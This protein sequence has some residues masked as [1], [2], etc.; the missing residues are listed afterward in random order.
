MTQPKK[1]LFV[2]IRY[3]HIDEFDAVKE[4]EKVL[5]RRKTAWFGKYGQPLSRDLE[6]IVASGK[7]DVTAILIR[8]G[9]GRGKESSG[10]QFQ[11]F[12]VRKIAISVPENHA[13]FPP[14]Y[15]KLLPRIRSWIQVE[16]HSGPKVDLADLITKSS[17]MP[18]VSS[19]SSSMRGHF[20]CRSRKRD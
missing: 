16:A 10:Y 9:T 18:V 11:Q 6:R 15:L 12:T 14:Y 2:L 4:L 8:K 1:K 17:A 5:A 20:L 7:E 3:G 19:L 13:E